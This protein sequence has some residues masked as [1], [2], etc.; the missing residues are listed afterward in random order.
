MELVSITKKLKKVC[1]RFM[2]GVRCL[3]FFCISTDVLNIKKCIHGG[4]IA[5]SYANTFYNSRSLDPS[6]MSY[7]H[8]QFNLYDALPDKKKQGSNNFHILK[9][10]VGNNTSIDPVL[11]NTSPHSHT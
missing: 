7:Q 3:P 6:A 10:Y 11:S 2:E 5:I 1:K 8:V 4:Y 9:T